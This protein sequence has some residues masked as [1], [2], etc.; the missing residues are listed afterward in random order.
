VRRLLALHPIQQLRALGKLEAQFDPP[1]APAQAAPV[2]T[3]TSAPAPPTVLSASSSG[4]SPDPI[5]DAVERGDFRAFSA[6]AN[7][8]ALG[9]K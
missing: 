9:R 6:A 4:T 7:A 1:T 5:A 3:V 8:A 2:K